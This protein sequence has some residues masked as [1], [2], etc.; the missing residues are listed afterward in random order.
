[1]YKSLDYKS[2]TLDLLIKDG[3]NYLD[4]RYTEN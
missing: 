3:H 1:M 4:N 2:L